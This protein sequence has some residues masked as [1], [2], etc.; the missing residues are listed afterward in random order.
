MSFI[1][2]FNAPPFLLSKETETALLYRVVASFNRLLFTVMTFFLNFVKGIPV[3]FTTNTPTG[4][5]TV[6][7]NCTFFDQ[8]SFELKSDNRTS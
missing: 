7:P 6:S 2:I 4:V 8:P 1:V 5:E 3:L